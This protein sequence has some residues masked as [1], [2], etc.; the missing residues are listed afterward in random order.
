MFHVPINQLS[1]QKP[2][3]YKPCY[4][5]VVLSKLELIIV[6]IIIVNNNN[7]H[8]FNNNKSNNNYKN[9][10]KLKR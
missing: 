1:K 3:Y 7:K 4:E 9:N 8:K 10:C 6:I 5:A 2:P